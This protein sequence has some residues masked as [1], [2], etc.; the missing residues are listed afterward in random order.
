MPTLQLAVQRIGN[1]SYLALENL[2]I[3]GL[4]PATTSKPPAGAGVP[5]PPLNEQML[6]QPPTSDPGLRALSSAEQSNVVVGRAWAGYFLALRNAINGIM[7]PSA[8]GQSAI[9]VLIEAPSI[10][11]TDVEWYAKLTTAVGV[12]DPLMF[13]P[14]FSI[15]KSRYGR[16]FQPG[17]YI[18]I[19]DFNI[20]GG[21]YNFEIAQ[22]TA[23]SNAGVWTL[24]RAGASSPPG[25]ARF[26]TPLVA[27]NPA[28]AP[29]GFIAIYRLLDEFWNIALPSPATPQLKKLP[30]D[31]MCVAAVQATA[32]GIPPVL[33]PLIP[34][35]TIN[36]M[37]QQAVP[38]FRTLNGAEYT[39]GDPGAIAVGGTSVLR[40]SVAGW[41]SIRNMFFEIDGTTPVTGP[42]NITL[43][44]IQPDRKKAYQLATFVIATGTRASYLATALPQNRRNPYAGTWPYHANL[45]LMVN[46]LSAA[47]LLQTGFTL[48]RTTTATMQE[49][50]EIDYIVT[51]IAGT[52]GS[53]LR[54]QVQT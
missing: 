47:G 3:T 51:A 50:G 31:N 49:D 27:H 19:A 41:H 9:A 36:G 21:Q 34:P 2:A 11:E 23:I 38:G 53:G 33:L 28:A 15:A 35:V 6:G 22:L 12:A 39:L 29:N 16:M 54:G 8:S 42:T 46:G 24:T 26:A 7:P 48:D 5:P 30:W 1:Y 43:A 10:D 40:L 32:A 45:P 4:A 14:G 18:M 17:D 13:T 20:T 52:P 25:Q 44:Y 37:I